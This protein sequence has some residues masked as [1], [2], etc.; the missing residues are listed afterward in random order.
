ME[1]TRLKNRL[2]QPKNMFKIRRMPIR[3]CYLVAGTMEM[4][5]II[6]ARQV[7]VIIIKKSEQPM[8]YLS[9][10]VPAN[11]YAADDKSE[12]PMISRK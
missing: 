3:F 5:F 1:K 12:V 8:L 6:P 4:S 9:T 7:T 2:K 10:R 11:P